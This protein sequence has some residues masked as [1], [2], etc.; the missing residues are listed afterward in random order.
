[1]GVERLLASALMAR[2]AV[3][4]ESG[5]LEGVIP[6]L[7]RILAIW[8]KLGD[9]DSEA[10]TLAFIGATYQRSGEYERSKPF[11]AESLRLHMRLG[12]YGELISA[13]VGLHFLSASMAE[14]QEQALDAARV[15]GVMKAWEQYMYKTPSPWWE[16]DKE[17]EF[18]SRVVAQIGLEGME[19]GIAEG[20]RMATAEIV[21]LCE[22]ITAPA[23]PASTQAVSTPREAPETAQAGMTPRELEVL[24]LVAQG[25]T[26]AQV[27][28]A[29]VITPR[30]V[31]AHLTAIYAKLSV[32][33]RS[34]AIR[35]ALEH[36]LG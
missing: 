21:A 12:A 23:H 35:Y 24:R 17:K 33:S 10:S 25:L 14:T 27:A 26:N 29:L 18:R 2:D 16:S 36:H 9:L 6:D 5:R 4:V 31:N 19:R 3:A 7:G 20:R 1:V 34:G 32:S 30:T 15:I 13:L 22:R 28:Q 11:I 8:R